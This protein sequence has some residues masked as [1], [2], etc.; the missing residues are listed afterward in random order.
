MPMWQKLYLKQYSQVYNITLFHYFILSSSI[1][2]TAIS[3]KRERKEREQIDRRSSISGGQWANE[4]EQQH[5]E[6]RKLFDLALRWNHLDGA[7][8]IASFQKLVCNSAYILI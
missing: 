7:K 5:K 1:I 2:L 8:Q 4:Q 3:K 6:D